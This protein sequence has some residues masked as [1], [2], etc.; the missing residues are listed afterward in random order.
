MHLEDVPHEFKRKFRKL[1]LRKSADWDSHLDWHGGPQ[2]IQAEKSGAE[3]W[4]V[5]VG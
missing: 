3:K 4:T 5:L 2:R 1:L